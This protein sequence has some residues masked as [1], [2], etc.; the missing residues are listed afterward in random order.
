[1]LSQLSGK[2]ATAASSPKEEASKVNIPSTR[3]K[4]LN[5]LRKGW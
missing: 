2:P 3:M 1:M 5:P 4:R